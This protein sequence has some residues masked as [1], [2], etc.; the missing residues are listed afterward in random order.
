MGRIANTLRHRQLASAIA[1][2]PNKL[3]DGTGGKAIRQDEKHPLKHPGGS[4]TT[5]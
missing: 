2:K 4:I 3:P 5:E 1:Y